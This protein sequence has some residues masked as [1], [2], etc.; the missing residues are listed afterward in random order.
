MLFFA[1]N[2]LIINPAVPAGCRNGLRVSE[3][4]QRYH[5]AV[6]AVQHEQLADPNAARG[7]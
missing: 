6:T 1:L 4:N 2:L 7:T 5:G 3:E